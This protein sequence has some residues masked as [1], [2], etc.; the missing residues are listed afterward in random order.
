MKTGTAN[1]R[2][3]RRADRET[4]SPPTPPREGGP[5]ILVTTSQQQFTVRLTP[6]PLSLL[7]SIVIVSN[8][9]AS[10]RLLRVP[11]CCLLLA[12]RP[13]AGTGLPKT[14]L[15]QLDHTYPLPR[16]YILP[17]NTFWKHVFG[18]SNTIS[19]DSRPQQPWPIS[20]AA[21]RSRSSTR[22]S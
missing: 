5:L 15:V 19:H 3:R 21:R 17:V 12:S 7:G 10:H 22:T 20:R 6:P 18:S 8:I 11:L 2:Y 16:A 1:C 13:A 4:N 9:S 14:E